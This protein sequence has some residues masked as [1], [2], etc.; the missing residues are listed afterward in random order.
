MVRKR[1][2][3]RKDASDRERKKED[4]GEDRERFL[5]TCISSN[6]NKSNVVVAK[7]KGDKRKRE[8][9]TAISPSYPCVS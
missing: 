1:E 6:D 8:I 4:I 3:N 5:N 7:K 9:A 2:K